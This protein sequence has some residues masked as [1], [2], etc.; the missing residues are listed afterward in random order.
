VQN[1]LAVC[2]CIC[3][4]TRLAIQKYFAHGDIPS[5]HSIYEGIHMLPVG[6]NLTFDLGHPRARIERD[7]QFELQP[8]EAGG[9]ANEVEWDEAVCENLGI[10]VTKLPNSQNFHRGHNR[11]ILKRALAG[12][13][14][15]AIRECPKKSF[16]IPIGPWFRDGDLYRG[17]RIRSSITRSPS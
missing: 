1:K 10:F 15:A 13:L 8:E 2:I 9:P 12:V 5:P 11:V 4:A 17:Q 7:W 14:P 16:G 3:A 6:S